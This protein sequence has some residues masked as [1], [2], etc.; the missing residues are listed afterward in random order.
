MLEKCRSAYF[1]V[2]KELKQPNP[3]NQP[4]AGIKGWLS[5]EGFLCLSKNPPPSVRYIEGKTSYIDGKYYITFQNFEKHPLPTDL[6]K[7]F[8]TGIKV[9]FSI[10]F[11]YSG[12]LFENI[13]SA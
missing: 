9:E 11:S 12:I 6:V 1:E 5:K 7:K 8:S 4:A 3:E 2:I 13:T 10:A